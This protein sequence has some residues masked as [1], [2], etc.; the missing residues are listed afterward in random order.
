MRVF[1]TVIFMGDV[2]VL[3]RVLPE[4][5]DINLDEL[6]EN[7]SKKLDGLCKIN[8]VKR[9][10]IGFGLNALMFS[11]IVPDEEGKMDRVENAISS[12]EH[13]SQVDTRDVTLI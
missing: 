11:I 2:M 4:S 6:K 3:L 8:E 5:I 10:E 9:E 7:I 1:G 13:V 12:V